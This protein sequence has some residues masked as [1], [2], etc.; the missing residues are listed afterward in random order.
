[1]DRPLYLLIKMLNLDITGP[2]ISY[3]FQQKAK[4]PD[5]NVTC[6]HK[7][8]V[9]SPVCMQ[10]YSLLNIPK[11]NRKQRKPYS[12]YWC[13]IGHF[14]SEQSPHFFKTNFDNCK[15]RAVITLFETASEL[16]TS[17]DPEFTV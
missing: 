16:K 10:R 8:S 13:G 12:K 2:K 11:D 15:K 14:T 17:I 7:M 1:M 5:N 6:H 4:T 3:K 9:R